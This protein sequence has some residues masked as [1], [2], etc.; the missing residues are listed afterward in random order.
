MYIRKY[1]E[2]I[3][4]LLLPSELIYYGNIPLVKINNSWYVCNLLWVE[5]PQHSAN[6]FSLFYIDERFLRKPYL[7]C[8]KGSNDQ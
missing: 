5:R 3:V 1:V 4:N 6:P 2:V 8:I 7:S